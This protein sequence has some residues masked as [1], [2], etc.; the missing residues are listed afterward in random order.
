MFFKYIHKKIIIL[1]F[2][3][4]QFLTTTQVFSIKDAT[5]NM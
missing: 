1:K 3:N 2:D 4:I 5:D